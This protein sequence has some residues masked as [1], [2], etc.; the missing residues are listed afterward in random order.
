MNK[1]TYKVL[2]ADDEHWTREKLRNLIDWGEYGLIFLEPATDGEDAMQKIKSN[3]P[4]ILITDIN[5]PFMNGVRLL[6]EIQSKYPHMV[7][8]VISGYDD[9]EYVKST[10]ISGAINY[11]I[12]PVSKI[13][14]VNALTKALEKISKYE[15][16]QIELLKAASMIQDREY[17]QLLNGQNIWEFQLIVPNDIQGLTGMSLILIKIHDL[18]QLMKKNK[19]DNNL[20]SYKIKTEIRSV[21]NDENLIVFNNSNRINEY[22]IITHLDEQELHKQV[23]KL[24]V[25][26][27]HPLEC[28][29]TICISKRIY[30]NDNIQQNYVDAVSLLMTRIYS[31]VDQIIMDHGENSGLWI[32]HATKENEKQLQS[33][34]A[35]GNVDRVKRVIFSNMGLS[36]CVE[37]K[38]SYLEVKQLVRRVL[39]IMMEYCIRNNHCVKAGEVE[40]LTDSVDNAVSTLDFNELSRALDDAIVE[41]VPEHNEL[42]GAGI[43]NEVYEVAKWIDE[44]YT[45]QITLTTLAEQNHVDSSYLSKVFH[46]EIGESLIVYIT[47]R[48]VERA[49]QYI[50]NGEN[51]LAEIA[52]LVGY[53]DYAYFSRVFKKMTGVSPNGYR[54]NKKNQICTN[55][56]SK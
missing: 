49:K 42:P 26:V 38:W 29:V 39:N 18:A 24:R 28:C 53:D 37:Q 1:R 36:Q 33:A 51:G 21:V 20:L 41:L 3:R 30:A 22:I 5:M 4:D 54:K 31:H 7:T 25:M 40:S 48:R 35:Q 19:Y 12:K 14:L 13:Q 15:T 34:L 45:E 11:L 44:H 10:F 8:F 55:E 46:Q 17:S 2:I 23:D 9:F 16:E 52:F 56:T 50:E 32:Q 43:R 6:E 47:K 27:F